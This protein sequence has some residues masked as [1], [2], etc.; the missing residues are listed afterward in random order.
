MRNRKYHILLRGLGWTVSLVALGLAGLLLW[1]NPASLVSRAG[2]LGLTLLAVGLVLLSLAVL[3]RLDRALGQLRRTNGALSSRTTELA[4]LHAIGREIPSSTDPDRVFAILERECS[5]IFELDAFIIGLVDRETSILR[6]AHGSRRGSESEPPGTI[7]EH[8]G[9]VS[10]VLDEKRARRV[11][12]LRRHPR[13]VAA[14]GGLID[15]CSRSV[16][17]V[18]LI[19]EGQVVGILSVQSRRPGAF[20]DHQLSVLTTIAQQAVVAI[21][22]ARHYQMATVDSLTGFFTRDYFFRRLGEED[23]RVRRYGGHFALLMVDIDGF[24]EINDKN[25]HLAGDQYLTAVAATIRDQ[26]RAADLACRYGGDEFCL[27]L[28]ETGLGGG[29][30]IAE[31]VRN[32]VSRKIVGVDG[33]ALRTTVSIGVAVFPEHDTGDLRGLMRNADEALYRAKR[34]GRDRV[35]PFAA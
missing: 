21:E 17:A 34:A 32:A 35:V 31:R 15:P 2:A 7:L 13:L 5:K 11:D 19:V 1:G 30:A 29:R 16:L 24:K 20:D 9:L 4:A 25:G 3:Q 28:P 27:L 8:E 23:K 26:L 33:L 18:P 14:G 12:D 6:I 22:N 10:W